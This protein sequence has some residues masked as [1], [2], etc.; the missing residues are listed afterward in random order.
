GANPRAARNVRTPR[1]APLAS[2]EIDRVV[3]ANANAP[4]A[5]EMTRL[6]LVVMCKA[7]LNA[8]PTSGLIPIPDKKNNAIVMYTCHWAAKVNVV[9]LSTARMPVTRPPTV[10]AHDGS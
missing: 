2:L 7:A 3:A 4:R 5:E 10:V 9:W 6:T 8:G 1:I